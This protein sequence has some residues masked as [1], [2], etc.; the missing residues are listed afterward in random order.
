MI[1]CQK[2]RKEDY[3]VLFPGVGYDNLEIGVTTFEDMIK[4]NGNSFRI[5][6]IYRKTDKNSQDY[7]N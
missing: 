2:N 3:Q 7:V 1:S 5:D 4:I 6:T